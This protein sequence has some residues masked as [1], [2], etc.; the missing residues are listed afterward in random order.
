MSAAF[1]CL[2]LLAVLLLPLFLSLVIAAALRAGTAPPP[3]VVI[4]SLLQ[5]EEAKYKPTN[6]IQE[7]ILFTTS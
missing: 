2:V 5:K 1:L 7:H 3:T 4:G 6:S